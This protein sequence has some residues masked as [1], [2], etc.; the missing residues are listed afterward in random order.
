MVD[1][2]QRYMVIT[3]KH[4]DGFCMFDSAL[5]DYKITNTSFGRDPIAEIAEALPKRGLKLGFYYSLLDCHHPDYGSNWP[6]Y[7]AY[8]QGQVRELCTKYGDLGM[9][10]FDGYWPAHESPPYFQ[11]SGSWDLAGTYD[12]IHELQPGALVGNNLVENNVLVNGSHRQLSL[13]PIFSQADSRTLRDNV[14][15]RNVVAYSERTAALVWCRPHRWYP[16]I[17]RECNENVYWFLGD[18]MDLEGDEIDI[19]PL[20]CLARWRDRKSVCADPLFVDPAGEDYSLQEG[21]PAFGMGFQRIPVER[22]GPEGYD[23]DAPTED[24]PVA[25]A[26]SISR[27]I[28]S[29]SRSS[30]VAVEMRTRPAPPAPNVS[31]GATATSR[32][33]SRR[34]A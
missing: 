24:Y 31:P 17:L 21:S 19:T 16:E 7:V 34:L 4:H 1:S 33:C 12:T 3:S 13:A 8:Y 30:L 26:N 14:I 20:G 15:R 25:T 11:P 10:W 23:P 32:S 28:P 27:P 18:R 6:A 22:I 29:R 5:S 2:G 9:I